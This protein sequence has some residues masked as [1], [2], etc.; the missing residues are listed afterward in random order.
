MSTVRED[1]DYISNQAGKYYIRFGGKGI[2]DGLRQPRY[3]RSYFKILGVH[4]ENEK[5]KWLRIK[6]YRR[7]TTNALPAHNFD[8]EYELI[9]RT[10]FLKLPEWA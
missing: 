9:D 4:K 1:I 2:M 7:R 5:I 10:Q 6:G 3:K 8:Q